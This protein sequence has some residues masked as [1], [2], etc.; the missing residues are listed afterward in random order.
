ME[1]INFFSLYS[2]LKEPN[3]YI[4]EIKADNVIWTTIKSRTFAPRAPEISMIGNPES[5]SVN[6]ER[7]N[8]PIRESI[9]IKY[10]FTK[11]P[12]FLLGGGIHYHPR[13][14]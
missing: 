1:G 14:K 8:A 2:K 7:Y 4:R 9:G 6:I 3:G 12:L 13:E 10:W 5:L 11:N